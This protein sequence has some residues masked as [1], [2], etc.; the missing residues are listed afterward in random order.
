MADVLVVDDEDDIRS[1]IALRV[2]RNGHTAHSHGDPREAL[3]QATTDHVDLALLDWNMPF[4][5]GGELCARLRALPHLA[6]IPV[7]I[8]TAFTDAETRAQ[9]EAAGATGFLTKPFRMADLDAV[10]ADALAGVRL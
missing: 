10:V 4:M 1:F 3:T 5:N 7:V 2:R 6:D 8:I 9:A